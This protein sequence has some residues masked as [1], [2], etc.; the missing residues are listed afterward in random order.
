MFFMQWIAFILIIALIITRGFWPNSFV[1]DKFSM[2]LLFLLSIPLLAPFLKKAKWFGAEFEFKEEIEKATKYVEI[3][4]EIA[5]KSKKYL[6]HR[7]ESTQSLF[8]TFNTKNSLELVGSD[9]NLALASL[10]IEI[11]KVLKN[12]VEEI[13]KPESTK[14]FLSNSAAIKLL[15]KNNIIFP[16]H[17]EALR[18]I[19]NMCNKAVHGAEISRNSAE[20]VIEITERLNNSFATGWSINLLPNE[21]YAEQGLV[22]EWEHCIEQSPLHRK[23]HEGTC[24]LFGHDCP[25]GISIVK[26]CEVIRKRA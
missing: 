10:R 4:E 14:K 18:S 1:I 3:T 16:E 5:K 24:T 20:E 17:S 21:S 13:L 8:Q 6:Q 11:E 19:I 26:S 23:E 9:P 15:Q 25:G 22:C 2:G 7:K 12:A